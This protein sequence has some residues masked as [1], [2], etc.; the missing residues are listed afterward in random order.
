MQSNTHLGRI[1]K[2]SI[3]CNIVE[4]LYINSI[5]YI[6]CIVFAIAYL[7]HLTRLKCLMPKI[8]IRLDDWIIF[9]ASRGIYIYILAGNLQ[10]DLSTKHRHSKICKI[11]V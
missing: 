4:L 1:A 11:H 8:I 5:V 2:N 9:N 3:I 6:Y 10:F 7:G